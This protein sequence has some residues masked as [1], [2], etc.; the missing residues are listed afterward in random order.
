MY[1]GTLVKRSGV[2]QRVCHDPILQIAQTTCRI[3]AQNFR[4]RLTSNH[5]LGSIDFVYIYTNLE[6]CWYIIGMAYRDVPGICGY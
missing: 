3:S 5:F 4:L 6:L 2:A 1:A